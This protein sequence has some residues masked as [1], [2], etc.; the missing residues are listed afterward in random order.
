MIRITSKKDG[1]RRCGVAHPKSATDHPDN[2]FT[3]DQLQILQAEPILV[4]QVVTG[5]TDPGG[6]SGPPKR[7]NVPD[8]VA[9]VIAA[10]TIEELNTFAEGE[11]RKG[12]L[13]AITKRGAEL[14]AAKTDPSDPP[15]PSDPSEKTE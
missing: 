13:D 12:V 8:T 11:D 6:K 7:L 9:L 10:A 3:E 5:G 4:V 15:D 2:R 1:F 14:A